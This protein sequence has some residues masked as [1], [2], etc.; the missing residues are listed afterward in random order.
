[1]K[2]I[3]NNTEILEAISKLFKKDIT[4]SELSDIIDNV[5][6]NYSRY[7]V[8]DEDNCGS[9][10]DAASEL[11]WLKTLKDILR[12]K[13]QLDKLSNLLNVE[14]S[15]LELSEILDNILFQYATY[16]ISDEEIIGASEDAPNQLCWLKRL[17]DLLRN[18]EQN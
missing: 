11:Y 2:Q 15:P 17:R 3:T 6:F 14:V 7:L 5:L 8:L 16:I 10:L 1:M 4:P 18:K 12:N 13:E 9:N